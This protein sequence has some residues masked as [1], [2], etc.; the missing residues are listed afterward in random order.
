MITT[1]VALQR[2][3]DLAT[4]IPLDFGECFASTYQAYI[5]FGKCSTVLYIDVE[6]AGAPCARAVTYST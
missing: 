3:I 2:L 5:S 6:G 4:S 1:V